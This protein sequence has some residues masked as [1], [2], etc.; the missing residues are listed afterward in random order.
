MTTLTQGKRAADFVLSEA[1]GGRSRDNI[2]IASGSGVIAP[3]TVLGINSGDEYEPSTVAVN[4][5]AETATVI[6]LYGGD[7]TS[8]AINVSAIARDAEVNIN[9]LVYAAD[10]DLDAE[11]LAK[12]TQLAAVG[13]ISR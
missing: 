13:I 2:T 11:K 8:V 10:V 9:Q 5:G 1:S 7:A 3:G 12:R 4:E 6:C